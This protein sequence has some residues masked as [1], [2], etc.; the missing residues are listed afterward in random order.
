[1]TASTVY[2]GVGLVCLFLYFH[3]GSKKPAPNLPPGPKPLLISGN[4]RDFPPLGSVEYQHWLKHKDLYGPISS[5][6]AMGQTIVIVHDRQLATEILDYNSLR[7]AE[8][9]ATEMAAMLHSR[10]NM[11]PNLGYGD[12]LRY[13]RK[14]FHLQ[15]G[16]QTLARR[17]QQEQDAE[18][19]KFLRRVL[20]E[21]DKLFH[22][23]Q[24]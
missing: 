4:A 19:R 15:M 9:P 13:L 1:M 17:F 20:D 22:H 12:D 11:M 7:S 5:V 24:L 16:T 18:C 10:I 3:Y 6:S 8:R 23:I 21:P 14:L 2:V